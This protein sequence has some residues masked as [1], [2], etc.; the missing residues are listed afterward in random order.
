MEPT[1]R[2]AD[3]SM[4]DSAA[5]NRE[6]RRKLG[7]LDRSGNRTKRAEH[8]GTWFKCDHL[9]MLMRKTYTFRRIGKILYCKPKKS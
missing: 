6:T 7:L 8:N 1:Y 2:L 3:G 4:F 5:Y 9:T